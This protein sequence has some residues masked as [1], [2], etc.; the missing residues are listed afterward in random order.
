MR[1][2]LK[3]KD[4]IWLVWD[5]NVNL[6]FERLTPVQEMV[7]PKIKEGHSLICKSVTGSGKTLAYLLPLM[8]QEDACL[9]IVPTRELVLQVCDEIK[10]YSHCTCLACF[11]KSDMT[12]QIKQIKKGIQFLVATPGRLLDLVGKK[13]VNLT[14]YRHLVID[15]ADVMYDC[16]F[17]DDIE[18]IVQGCTQAK[19]YLF[20]ATSAPWMKRVMPKDVLY[21]DVTNTQRLDIH[22]HYF[23]L[24][25]DEKIEALCRLMDA[26][27]LSS[28]MIFCNTIA[29][30]ETLYGRLNE[31][32]YS[33]QILHGNLTQEQRT[34]TFLAFRNHQFQYLITTDVACRGIDISQLTHVIN[35]D[36][37]TDKDTYTHRIGRVGRANAKG[38]AYSLVTMRDVRL[39]KQLPE[40]K[41]AQLPDLKTLY[42]NQKEAVYKDIQDV[43]NSGQHKKYM[44]EFQSL[45]RDE[46]ARVASALFYLQ[47]H[48][49]LNYDYQKET[50]GKK[51]KYKTLRFQLGKN[52]D[53]PL[54]EAQAYLKTE[55]RLSEAEVSDLHYLRDGFTFT[56]T[57]H[58]AYIK[59]MRLDGRL[60]LNRKIKI[61]EKN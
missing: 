4:V 1:P 8:E 23:M 25:D 19:R 14:M 56:V 24:R 55:G 11:G 22:E 36:F 2:L 35:F 26:Y 50:I 31:L 20:S 41:Q 60:F 33:C 43:L 18:K 34:Q 29:M 21:I 54:E 17:V 46:L 7:I 44:H 52:F 48:T 16:G 9:I 15:E 30:C 58:D 5:M 61:K 45:S 39:L 32:R 42:V 40:I 3:E 59:A 28:A 47:I 10:K 51:R 38:Q 49:H 37:P 12:K 57:S 6:P 13:V 27:H 53:F